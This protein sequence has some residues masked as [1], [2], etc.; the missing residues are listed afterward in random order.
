MF[1][2]KINNTLILAIGVFSIINTE[3]GV[4]GILPLIADYYHV[5]ISSA[6]LLVSLFALAVA[7][8]GPTLPLL[9]SRFNRKK[10]MILVLSAFMLSNL[11]SVFTDNFT[12]L[13]VARVLP[14][15]LH[16]VYVSMAFALATAGAAPGQEGK[17]AATIMVGVS[18]GMVLGVPM[19]S[20]ISSSVSLQA[21]MLFFTFVSALALLLTIIF[22]PS[23][24]VRERLS[25]SS[26]LRVLKEK[27]VLLAIVGVIFLNGSI[28]GVYSYLA[29]YLGRIMQMPA[30]TINILLMGYGLANIVG[31]IIGGRLLD[32]YAN[33][34]IAF[35]P[36]LLIGCYLALF[37]SGNISGLAIAMIVL[38]GV[39][40]GVSGNINQY[41]I[42]N[43]APEVP[44]FANGLFL[45]AANLGTT[46]GALVCGAFISGM[47][48]QYIIWGGILFAV[49]SWGVALVGSADNI[50]AMRKIVQSRV[51][52]RK[53]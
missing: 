13:L 51:V 25:Y 4:I 42:V 48:T 16:P 18:A 17:A 43:A 53:I 7:I 30:M 52:G 14:A 19:V 21:G 44:D 9:F 31:N 23:I 15:F 49:L 32:R 6:G 10:I 36:V 38:W 2:I 22:I 33:S 12:V 47:G 50:R 34:C 37:V 39:L 24:P 46:M 45:V 27:P 26:Q 3:M 11:L 20:T 5:S 8:A 35:F 40:A 28:F 1:T 29:E 41:W